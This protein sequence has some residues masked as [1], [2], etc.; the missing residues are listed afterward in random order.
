MAGA[1]RAIDLPTTDHMGHERRVE[2]TVDEATLV[3]QTNG[4]GKVPE[5]RRRP[6]IREVTSAGLQTALMMAQ[7]AIDQDAPRSLAPI[8]PL[9]MRFG[10]IEGLPPLSE[11]CRR[12]CTH[13]RTGR[14]SQ[15]PAK[16]LPTSY[17]D[18]YSLVNY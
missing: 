9:P 3:Q 6:E 12:L 1:H 7:A 8:A 13:R 16:G 10:S 4:H 11:I 15:D 2:R 5:E 17:Y 14:G 18:D